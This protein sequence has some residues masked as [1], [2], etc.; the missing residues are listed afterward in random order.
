VGRSLWRVSR[1]SQTVECC[2][3]ERL[4]HLLTADLIQGESGQATSN[5]AE[6]E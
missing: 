2:P 4:T 5:G 6:M 3:S 1:G